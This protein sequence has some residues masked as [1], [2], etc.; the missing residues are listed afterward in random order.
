MSDLNTTLTSSEIAQGLRAIVGDKG[1]VTDTETLKFHN[2][3]WYGVKR[4]FGA[5]LVKPASTEEVAAVV[6]FCNANNLKVIPQG[7][8]T[9]LM[10]GT[11]P[12][13]KGDEVMVSLARMN[14]ILDVNADGYTMTVEAGAI[15]QSIQDAAAAQDRFFPLR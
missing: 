2:D 10:A 6:R 13:G 1:L 11:A 4:G 9:G 7:G 5:A 8:L 12:L 15:L 3:D 14:R